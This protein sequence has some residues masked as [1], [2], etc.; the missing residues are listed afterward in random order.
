MRRAIEPYEDSTRAL[1]DRS[2]PRG[3]KKARAALTSGVQGG[4]PDHRPGQRA[5]PQ[6]R[7]L[8][9]VHW[10][11]RERQEEP[12][13][14]VAL[15]H[16]HAVNVAGGG[17]VPLQLR[18]SGFSRGALLSR[19]DDLWNATPNWRR[20]R[21]PQRPG[22]RGRRAWPVASS[23]SAQDWPS[24]SGDTAFGSSPR[25]APPPQARGLGWRGSGGRPVGGRG[26]GARRH[27]SG[28]GPGQVTC[29]TR[30]PST[31]AVISTRSVPF[32]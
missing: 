18:D 26:K 28:V 25:L 7:A 5:C 27:P 16:M 22:A 30:P 17:L 4:A 19:R 12:P 3:L 31:R 9:G 11:S 2:W 20:F 21:L 10:H 13:A 24:M 14:G 8:H 6:S 29:V 1:L 23:A 32:W 15:E